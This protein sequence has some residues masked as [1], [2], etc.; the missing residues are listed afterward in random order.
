MRE[1]GNYFVWKNSNVNILRV[2]QISF[3]IKQKMANQEE[4]KEK[5]TKSRLNTHTLGSLQLEH[6]EDLLF[7]WERTGSRFERITWSW[8]MIGDR[9]GGYLCKLQWTVDWKRIVVSK[10]KKTEVQD[11]YLTLPFRLLFQVLFCFGSMIN[12]LDDITNNITA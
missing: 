8:C 1:K 2:E 4:R 5:E 9:M 11:K 7:I 6:F 10:K 12:K 3:R